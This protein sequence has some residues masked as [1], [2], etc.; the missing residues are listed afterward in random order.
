MILVVL[1]LCTI[2]LFLTFVYMRSSALRLVLTAIFT[3]GLIASLVLVV[4]NDSQHYGMT[5]VTTTKTTTLK[6]AS[7]SSSMDMLLY[8]SVG[9]ADKHRV[10]IYKQ[11]SNQKKVSHTAANI[12]VAN[13]VKTT[14]GATKLVTKSTRWEYKNSTAKFWFGIADNDHKLIKRTNTFYVKKNWVVLSTTQ[15]KALSKLAK[16]QATT[17]K[18]R[19]K[20]YVQN[21]VQAAMVKNP[22]MSKAQLAKLEKQAA[23]EYQA[24]AMKSM[25]AEAKS[26]TK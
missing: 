21:K 5:K 10:Y 12:K 25:I 1:V 2:A 19:A 7:S 9:T 14:T 3:L 6:S 4:E 13:H 23:A 15:A 8:Q 20:V 11:T 17:L 26:S 22:S 18:A 24:S 16:Q